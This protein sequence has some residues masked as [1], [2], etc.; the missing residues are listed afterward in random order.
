MN[1]DKHG[2]FSP[3]FV[4]MHPAGGKLIKNPITGTNEWIPNKDD[5]ARP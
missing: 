5:W 2:I 3:M 1:M 4:S